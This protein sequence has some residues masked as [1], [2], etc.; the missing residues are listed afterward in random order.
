[1]DLMTFLLRFFC[2]FL[3]Y[4]CA[5]LIIGSLILLFLKLFVSPKFFKYGGC[6]IVCILAALGSFA[7]LYSTDWPFWTPLD[8]LIYIV[9]LAGVICGYLWTYIAKDCYI[10]CPAC[11]SWEESKLLE[12]LGGETYNVDVTVEKDIYNNNREKIGYFEDT[13]TE[14]RYREYR[15]YKCRRCGHIFETWVH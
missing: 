10:V 13:K 12:V 9:I 8:Q 15:R 14:T 3:F 11:N 6:Y 5:S 2:A 4:F 1:M 7:I